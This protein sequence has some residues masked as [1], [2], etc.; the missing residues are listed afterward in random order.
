MP[1]KS[2]LLCAAALASLFGACQPSPVT[3]E[4]LVLAIDSTAYHRRGQSPLPIPFK[5][6]N[7]GERPV[8]VPECNG[9]PSVLIDYLS[10]GNWRNFDGGFCNGDG[11][12]LALVPGGSAEGTATLYQS[13]HFRLRVGAMPDPQGPVDWE[14]ASKPFDV[15]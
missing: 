11:S 10:W 14:T 5:V 12:T 9:Q 2:Y 7:N 1:S 13:G 8:Y 15:W 6:T 4:P 3:P